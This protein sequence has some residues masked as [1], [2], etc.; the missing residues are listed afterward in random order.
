MLSKLT[1]TVEKDT[2]EEAKSFAKKHHTSVSQLVEK[3]L[4]EIVTKEREF[5]NDLGPITKSLIPEKPFTLNLTTK[6]L[7][8]KAKAEKWL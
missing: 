5:L 4:K 2:I 7:I 8:H 6:E 3:H 1:L